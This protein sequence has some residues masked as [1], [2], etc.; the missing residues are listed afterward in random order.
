MEQ[1]EE[2]YNNLWKTINVKAGAII[3]IEWENTP[4]TGQI[5]IT[6]Y[7]AENNSVTGHAAGT[8]LPGAVFEIVRERS[9]KVVGYITTDA[10][11]VAASSP[12][13]LGRYI[14]REVTAPAYYQV[15]AEKFDMTLE[16]PGQIIKLSA[17]DKPA[18]LSVTILKT[19][20]KEVLA[21][22]RMTYHFTVANGSN[23]A[24][25]NFFW[26]DKLPYFDI[27]I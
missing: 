26:H 15:S 27:F 4:I 21:G 7:A 5:Q 20:V 10:H 9:G 2:G 1:S 17:Y 22:S 24:L 19:G 3:Q 11:G 12:L 18:Q 16:Y 14:L 13:P 25:E 23:V 8:A 6:K